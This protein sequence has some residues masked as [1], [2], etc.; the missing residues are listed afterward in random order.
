MLKLIIALNIV[1][2]LAAHGQS[3]FNPVG[4]LSYCPKVTTQTCNVNK[5]YSEIDGSC[6][7]LATPW[8]GRASTPYKRYFPNAY[9]DQWN[10]PRSRSVN[11]APLQNPRAIS[12]IIS[13]D[14]N[15]ND[16]FFSHLFPLFG[17][18]LAH[19]LTLANTVTGI[20]IYIYHNSIL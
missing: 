4:P 5:R 3:V 10:A 18:F 12:R 6:N 19:D 7:N 8:A 9:N 15:Q 14:R 11:T 17:Q 20:Y 1:F 16:F 13:L 2:A